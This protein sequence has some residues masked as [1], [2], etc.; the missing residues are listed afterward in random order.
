MGHESDLAKGTNHRARRR[1]TLT[2]EGC[3]SAFSLLILFLLLGGFFYCSPR[4]NPRPCWLFQINLRAQQSERTVAPLAAMALSSAGVLVALVRSPAFLWMQR[5]CDS[6]CSGQADSTG[7]TTA[8]RTRPS[9]RRRRRGTA[10]HSV[11][12]RRGRPVKRTPGMGGGRVA[13]R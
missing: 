4:R 2:A 6:S 1:E 11:F 9:E 7:V 8:G 5:V 3:G 12:T 13:V 10:A